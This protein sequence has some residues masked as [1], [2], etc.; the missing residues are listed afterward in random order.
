MDP[1]LANRLRKRYRHLR[2]WAQRTSIT[3]FRLYERDI[4]EYPLVVDWYDGEAVVWLYRRKRD[5]TAAQVRAWRSDVLAQVGD[6]L[7][8]APTQLFVKERRIQRG[9]A[10]YERLQQR[11]HVRTVQEQG[12]K[13][14]VNLSDFLDTG[15][16]LDHRNTRARVR[17]LAAGKRVLN[18]FAY[19]GSFT[20]YALDG[21]ASFTKTVDLSQTYCDWIRRN[22]RHNGFEESAHHQIVQ[23]DAFALLNEERRKGASYDLIICDPPTFSN[24]KRKGSASFDV[25]RD[26]P[27]LLAA[28]GSL[29][30]EGGGILFSSN[31]RRFK[32]DLKR[33][34]SSFNARELTPD[35]VPQDFR[36]RRIHQCWWLS[37]H[38]AP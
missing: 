24:S 30:K 8:L 13:F 6:G 22:F 3:C 2:K 38:T 1:V 29:L 25:V 7:E 20:I 37:Q 31:A 11:S 21:G 33:I 10:Q 26:Y 34:P 9:N 14:E 28:C 4:P 19:T 5:E 36:N 17:E 23:A 15:L 35:T 16:F 32:L 27:R 18:L 12:L